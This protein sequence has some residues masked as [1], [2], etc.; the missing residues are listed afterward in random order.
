MSQGF[1]RPFETQEDWNA[2][3]ISQVEDAIIR[4]RIKSAR[5]L[6]GIIGN[7]SK[8]KY[9]NGEQTVGSL[10]L[11]L[12]LNSQKDSNSNEHDFYDRY[13]IELK[14]LP[15]KESYSGLKGFKSEEYQKFKLSH[16]DVDNFTKQ[17]YDF[18]MGKT[19][20]EKAITLLETEKRLSRDKAIETII[21]EV[22]KIAELRRNENYL[23]SILG[24]NDPKEESEIM[25]HLKAEEREFNSL[26][27]IKF[28]LSNIGREQD[29]I[30]EASNYQKYLKYKA[31]YLALKK[32]LEQK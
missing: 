22:Q 19:L 18:Q 28:Y 7:Q 30:S 6:R 27:Q 8:K 25:K 9:A 15:T 20:A 26:D 29:L 24:Q 17:V 3:R 16:E 13:T 12:K 14:K 21:S 1:I 2:E 32:Q 31:K 10:I 5:E 4:K 23:F 11:S